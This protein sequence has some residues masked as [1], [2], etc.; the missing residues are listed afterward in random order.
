M[1]EVAS[2]LDGWGLNSP[3]YFPLGGPVDVAQLPGPTQSLGRDSSVL[4]VNVD[5]LLPHFGERYPIQWHFQDVS[6]AYQG[7]H[8]LAVAPVYGHPLRPGTTYAFIL[9]TDVVARSPEFD[10]EWESDSTNYEGLKSF[11]GY[12]A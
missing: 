1:S 3:V 2:T 10:A 7:E 6:T 4:V 11:F 12:K 8:V 9:T 5:T